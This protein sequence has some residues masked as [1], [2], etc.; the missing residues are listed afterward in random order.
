MRILVLIV[1]LLVTPTFWAQT[2]LDPL[3][4]YKFNGNV[5]DASGNEYHGIP[6]GVTFVEDREGNPERAVRF[7]GIDDFIDLP[8]VTDLKPDLPVTFSFWVKYESF[9]NLKQTVFNTSL[10][11][12][13]SSGVF[14]NSS[15][16]TGGY[17]ISYGDGTPFYSGNTR[18]TYVSNSVI[19][20]DQWHHVVAI[21]RSATDMSIYVDCVEAGGTYNGSGGPLFYSTTPGVIGRHDRNL[22]IPFEYFMGALDDFRYWERALEERDIITLCNLLSVS[23]IDNPVES[24]L[25]VYPNPASSLIYIESTMDSPRDILISDALGRVVKRDAFSKQINISSLPDGM[26]FLSIQGPEGVLSQKFIV[27]R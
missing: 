14:F 21:V 26:Y 8:N 6:N 24:E 2:Y 17:A 20:L 7:D 13:V 3:L 15:S 23:D 27:R 11:D 18:R 12:D 9:D 19:D 25:I 1:C 16:S 10:E 5:L 22:G 4:L